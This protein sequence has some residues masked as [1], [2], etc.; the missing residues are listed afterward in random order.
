MMKTNRYCKKCGKQLPQGYRKK[1]CEACMGKAV[2][3]AKKGVGIGG[4][5]AALGLAAVKIIKKFI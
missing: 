3:N 1:Y 2:H 5:L 4:S